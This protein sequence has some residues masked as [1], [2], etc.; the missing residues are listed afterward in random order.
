MHYVRAAVEDATGIRLSLEDTR[1][2][3][4]EEGLITQAEAD[5]YAKIFVGYAEFFEMIEEGLDPDWDDLGDLN[6]IGE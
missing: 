5:K 4:V 2:Y 6:T 3:L 1:R